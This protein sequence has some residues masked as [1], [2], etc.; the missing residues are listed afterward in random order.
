MEQLQLRDNNLYANGSV[1]EFSGNIT[2]LEREPLKYDGSITD[3]HHTV[4]QGE[5]LTGLAYKYYKSIS[6]DPAKYWWVLADV[7][8]IDNPFDISDWIG[9]DILIPDLI[10]LKLRE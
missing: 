2:L 8:S 5:T 1:L 4:I 10:M 7:N 3:R 9:K 6:S